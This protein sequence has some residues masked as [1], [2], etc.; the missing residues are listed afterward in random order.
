MIGVVEVGVALSRPPRLDRLSKVVVDVPCDDHRRLW[1]A[2]QK[3]RVVACWMAARRDVVMVV[4]AEV[5]EL[6]EV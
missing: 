4:S 3:A 2:E 6:L 1:A 5:T